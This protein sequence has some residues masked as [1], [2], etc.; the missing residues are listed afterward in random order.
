MEGATQFSGLLHFTLDP[1]IIMLSAKQG[2]MKYHLKVFGMTRPGT[3]P[4][5]PG[6]LANTQLIR[7]FMY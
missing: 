1:Y 4:G 7:R 3:E 6:P 2:G 5:S